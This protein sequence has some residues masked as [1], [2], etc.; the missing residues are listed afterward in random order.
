MSHMLLFLCKSLV[1]FKRFD[2]QNNVRL[3]MVGETTCYWYH[4]DLSPL[5]VVTRHLFC[6]HNAHDSTH[7]TPIICSL[8]IPF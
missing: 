8:S 5:I 6:M 2:F 4:H 3:F 7:D 1:K